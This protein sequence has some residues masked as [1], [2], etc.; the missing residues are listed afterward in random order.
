MQTLMFSATMPPVVVELA[1]SI[2]ANPLRVSIGDVNAAATDVE[3]T[4]KFI[5]S[6]ASQGPVALPQK[7]SAHKG[8]KEPD[9]SRRKP[10]RKLTLIFLKVDSLR[11]FHGAQGRARRKASTTRVP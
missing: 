1:G 10:W 6:E 2:L 11:E 5:T 7:P 9:G 8:H 3:Q 4:L